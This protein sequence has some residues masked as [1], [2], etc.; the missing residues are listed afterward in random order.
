MKEISIQ[1]LK[2]RLSAIVAEAA[3]GEEYVITRHKHP[4]ARVS[5]AGRRYLQQGSRF[6]K[7]SLKP[8]LDAKTKGRYLQILTE[9]REETSQ[10][11]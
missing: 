4:V 8:L 1:E 6:G 7:G 2:R 11:G 3:E 9:D 5:P 10:E